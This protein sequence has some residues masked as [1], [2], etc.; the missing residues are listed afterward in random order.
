MANF[1]E[2]TEQKSQNKTHK[3]GPETVKVMAVAFEMGFI[4]ALP[5]VFFAFLGKT[6]DAKYHTNYLI[7]VGIILA[8]LSS[9]IWIYRRFAEMIK[10]LEEAAKIK[11]SQ[12][13]QDNKD[14]QENK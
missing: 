1:E 9:T 11:K 8:V 5:I 6:L 3:Y 12:D 4:I 14:N 13:N 2:S 7:F 10:K